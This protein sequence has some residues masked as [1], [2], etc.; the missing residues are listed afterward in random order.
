MPKTSAKPPKTSGIYRISIGPRTFY[1]G[2][3]Q[4]LRKRARNHLTAL[5]CGGHGNRHL[6]AS[7]DKHGESAYTFEV[8]LLCPVE[9]LNLQEQLCLDIYHGTPGCANIAKVAE[10]S[11]RGLKRSDE[12]KAKMSKAKLGVTKTAEHA[13]AIRE[14]RRALHPNILVERPDGSVEI[15]PS[16][17][18]LAR[19]LGFKN[20]GSVSMW[21]S[22]R[23][24]IP[25]KHNITSIALTDLPVTINPEEL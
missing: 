25:A 1:S 10:A 20:A 11:Q 13:G 5:R 7:F 15:W 2:Q 19:G 23:Q 6:Q 14:A 24:P 12:T 3:A 8:S 16:Q 22:R 4:N 21:L 9:D 18:S 17:K